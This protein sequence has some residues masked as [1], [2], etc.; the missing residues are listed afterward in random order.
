MN[1]KTRAYSL[2]FFCFILVTKVQ[3]VQTIKA[4]ELKLLPPIA[5]NM[6]INPETFLR[7]ENGIGAVINTSTN[8]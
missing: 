1:L 7:R 2:K 6:L 5:G 8:T 3:A 4:Y